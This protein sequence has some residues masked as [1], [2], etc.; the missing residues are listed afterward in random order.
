MKKKQRERKLER[1]K[2][3]HK[4]REKDSVIEGKRDRIVSFVETDGQ[5]ARET[6][7]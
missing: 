7:R 3:I 2:D 6:D 5:M 1:Q 4:D